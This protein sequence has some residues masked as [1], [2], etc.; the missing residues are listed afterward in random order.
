MLSSFESCFLPLPFKRLFIKILLEIRH[1]SNIISL[2]NPLR[3]VCEWT[4][5]NKIDFQEVWAI[6]GCMLCYNLI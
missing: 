1:N 5:F 3:Y 6:Y 4:A 2:Q